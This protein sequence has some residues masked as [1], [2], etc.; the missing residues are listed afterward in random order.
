MAAKRL[1]VRP[2]DWIPTAPIVIEAT[3]TIEAPVGTVWSILADHERWPEWFSVL[4]RVEVTGAAE[5]VGGTRSVHAKR[6]RLDEEFTV[7]EPERHFVFSIVGSS[8]PLFASMAESIRLDPIGDDRSAVAY[9]QGL[10]PA[11]YR[12]FIVKG[13]RKKLESGLHDALAKLASAAEAR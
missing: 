12:G 11:R 7:W 6:L 3:R 4:E 1:P 10:E 13:M 2:A 8:V 5:G 9:S